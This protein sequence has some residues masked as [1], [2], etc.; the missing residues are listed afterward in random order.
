LERR[1]ITL[2]DTPIS[3]LTEAFN[4]A[5]TA[6]YVPVNLTEEGMMERINRA[7][8]NLDLSVGILVGEE[9]VAFML[10]VIG[11]QGGLPTADNART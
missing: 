6:Y 9:L 4:A 7:R 8:V 3:L 10:S 1:L 2:G 5:F 11:E